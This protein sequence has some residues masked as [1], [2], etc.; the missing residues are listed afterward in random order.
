MAGIERR[1]NLGTFVNLWFYKDVQISAGLWMFPEIL[2]GP[3][4]EPINM[5]YIFLKHSC[6]FFLLPSSKN[7]KILL[8]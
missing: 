6:L 2:T 4:I 7:Q 1:L 8:L 3:V 5:I